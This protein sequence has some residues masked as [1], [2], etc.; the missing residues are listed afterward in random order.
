M[1]INICLV[2]HQ[3]YCIAFGFDIDPYLFG[4]VCF[5]GCYSL[6]PVLDDDLFFPLLPLQTKKRTVPFLFV[7]GDGG[8]ILVSPPLR[9]AWFNYFYWE[10]NCWTFNKSRSLLFYFYISKWMRFFEWQYVGSNFQLFFDATKR[11]VC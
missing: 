8:V 4:L 9:T 3:L 6:G 1:M 7:R 5:G 10:I 11:M 2:F